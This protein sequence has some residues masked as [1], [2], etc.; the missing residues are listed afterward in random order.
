VSASFKK[1]FKNDLLPKIDKKDAGNV[2]SIAEPK[3]L[4][5]M[6]DPLK[7]VTIER[8]LNISMKY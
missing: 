1:D 5:R 4:P 2:S 3:P 7:Q 8:R 6:I